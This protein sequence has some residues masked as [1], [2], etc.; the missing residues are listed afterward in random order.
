[1]SMEAVSLA[2]PQMKPPSLQGAQDMTPADFNRPARPLD[3]L[4]AFILLATWFAYL[5]GGVR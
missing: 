2:P 1:M 5:V 4:V 3:L